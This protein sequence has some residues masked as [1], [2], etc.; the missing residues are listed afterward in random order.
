MRSVLGPALLLSVFMV[1]GC[2]SE[3]AAPAAP[4]TG[5]TPNAASAYLAGVLDIMQAHSINRCRIDWA[6][7]R[8]TAN[9]VAPNPVAI[10]DTYPAISAALGLLD[11]HHS[12]FELPDGSRLSNPNR[13]PC[14]DPEVATPT[15]PPD[16]GYVRVGPFSEWGSAGVAF[17]ADIQ[18]RIEAADRAGVLG[19]IVDL[20]GNSG[21]TMWPMIAGLGPILGEGA[22]GAFVYPDNQV[23][24][25]AYANGT[26]TLAGLTQ[27]QVPAPYLPVSPPP[28]VAVLTDCRVASAGEGTTIAFRG[29]PNTR[30]FGG[31]T[32][33]ISTANHA[34]PMTDGATLNLTVA[35][36]ADRHLVRYG[37]PVVPDE[38]TG[39]AASTVE[40]AIAWLR[41]R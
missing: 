27:V 24:H 8:Q 11:D 40:R 23:H 7:F 17:A 36:M 34:F 20:R 21:G 37:I 26:S 35:T 33:G 25:F 3:G 41:G 12:N 1:S 22:L 30:S 39:D 2:G 10:A 15:V 16:I 28:R 9:Q 31:P 38:P 14:S 5:G 13:L 6:S 29:R 4:S 32:R 18:R 19:W